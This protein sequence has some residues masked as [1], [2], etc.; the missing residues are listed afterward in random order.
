MWLQASPAAWLLPQSQATLLQHSSALQSISVAAAAAAP[1]LWT[2]IDSGI[3]R[4][5]V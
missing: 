3:P 2:R 4:E 5:F 1:R